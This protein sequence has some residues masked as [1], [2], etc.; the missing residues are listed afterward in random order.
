MMIKVKTKTI[1]LLYSAREDRM[2]LIINK[3]E[4]DRIECWITRRFYF[5]LLFELETFLEQLHIFPEPPMQSE[6]KK[7][8][9]QANN[10]ISTNQKNNFKE[11][12][13]LLE[14]KSNIK[15]TLLQNINIRFIKE[16]KSFVFVF[17][18]T[19]VEAQSILGIQGFLNLYNTFKNTFPK[20]EWGII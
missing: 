19:G 4:A 11:K 12:E 15:N 13:Y 5:S 1:S 18:S 16:K 6:Q 14:E 7:N 10:N 9:K 3:D 2:K 17:Q 8:K 20:R